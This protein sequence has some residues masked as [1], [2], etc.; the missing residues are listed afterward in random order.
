VQGS[1]TYILTVLCNIHYCNI[2]VL[3]YFTVYNSLFHLV[4]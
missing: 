1:S 2:D 4:Q 3:V